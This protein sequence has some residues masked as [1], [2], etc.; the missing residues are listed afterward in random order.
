MIPLELIGGVV[1]AGIGYAMKIHAL[2][3]QGLRD[4]AELQIKRDMV[5]SELANAAQKRGTPKARKA[6]AYV[7]AVTFILGFLLFGI[8]SLWN[9]NA[10][11]SYL[12]DVP[13]KSFMWGFAKWG[14][15]VEVITATGF[16][17]P[18][19]ARWVVCT[20][21]GFFFGTGAAK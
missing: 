9:D 4:V 13:Q 5:S 6:L 16:V 1:S 8:A 7:I 11:V 3:I 10:V 15:T 21:V 17:I 19:Y 2:T 12:V 18:P 14:K 20:V